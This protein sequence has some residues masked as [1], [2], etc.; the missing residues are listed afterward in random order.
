MFRPLTRGLRVVDSE[1]AVALAERRRDLEQEKALWGTEVFRELAVELRARPERV[2]SLPTTGF[3]LMSLAPALL[4]VARRSRERVLSYLLAQARLS[5]RMIARGELA[6]TELRQLRAFSD[7]NTRL[8]RAL[9][10]Q[11]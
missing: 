10:A 1:A 7:T 3:F 8:Q 6:S 11:G 5:E 4:M 9:A 2:A